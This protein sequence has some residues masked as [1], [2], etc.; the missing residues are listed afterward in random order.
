MTEDSERNDH[1]SDYPDRTRVRHRS[2]GWSVQ[3]VHPLTSAARAL[4]EWRA[5]ISIW[6]G[7]KVRLRGIEPGDWQ[8]FMRFDGPPSTRDGSDLQHLRAA[9]GYRHWAAHRARQTAPTDDFQLSIETLAG[10]VLVGSLST[11]QI[12]H[13]TGRFSYGIGIGRE[14][15]RQGYA[16]D[17]ITI[18]LTFMFGERRYHK[19]QVGIHGSNTASLSLHHKL[20]FREEGRLRDHEYCGEHHVDSVLMGVT[21]DEFAHRHAYS[22]L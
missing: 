4:V 8:A 21:A 5:M 11:T 2:S 12:E 1:V 14:H 17:A 18:L 15:Q 13:R 3:V 16:T 20:G 7:T 22:G 19:C 10:A 9:E 6:S